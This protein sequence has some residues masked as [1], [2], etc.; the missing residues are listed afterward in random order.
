MQHE[1]K[2]PEDQRHIT[3]KDKLTDAASIA[4]HTRTSLLKH[5]VTLVDKQSTATARYEPESA[6]E[7]YLSY[8][9]HSSSRPTCNAANSS[10]G[11]HTPH[12]S[13]AGLESA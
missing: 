11:S 1:T 5:P 9:Q 2:K 3:S 6:F 8:T 7:K 4:S 13:P 10:A 12:A